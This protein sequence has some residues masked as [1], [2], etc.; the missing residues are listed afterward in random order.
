MKIGFEAKKAVSNTT[1]IGN[2][3]RRCINALAAYGPKDTEHILFVPGH[4]MP[5]A[6]SKIHKDI[7]IVMPGR[8]I[9]H[10]GFLREVWRC[11]F[12]W[13]SIR[14]ENIGLYHGLSNELPFFINYSG[15]KTIVTIHDL[16]FIR[17]PETYGRLSRM[18][19]R[20]KTFYACRIADH[21]IAISETTKQDII[22]F[23]G[24]D[25][26]KISVVYQ[27]ISSD[28]RKPIPYKETAHCRNALRLPEKYILCV[29]TIQTRKNQKTIVKALAH[30]PENIHAVL[31]GKRTKYQD[32]VT[33]TAISCRLS[34]RL[35]IFN[36][37]PDKY[38]PVLY[39]TAVIFVLPSIFEGFG[40]PIAEALASGTPVVAATGSCLEEAGGP[41]SIYVDPCDAEGMANAILQVINDG[42]LR[43]DM[44]KRGKQYSQLFTDKSLAGNLLRVYGKIIN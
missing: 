26:N 13:Y 11:F 31:V 33:D 6:Y 10:N 34:H 32:E 39:K 4:I 38:L 15:C 7:K 19:L 35:H 24:I 20:A 8:C 21:I 30:L 25:E 3:S 9:R 28:F 41:D 43:N 42:K 5:K 36:N 12:S 29:G 22:N 14:R 2:Y 17:H 40:I 18:I 23:Y 1:G 27:S 44:T 37:L 16:I